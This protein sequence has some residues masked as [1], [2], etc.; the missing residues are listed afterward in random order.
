MAI[1]SYTTVKTLLGI[2]GTGEDA[3]LTLMAD[4][5]D[6]AIKNYVGYDIETAT[7]PDDGPTN[8]LGDTGY[9]SGHGTRLLLLRQRPVWN[10]SN[11]AIYQDQTGY[12]GANSD[13]AFAS[14]TLLTKG[15]DYVVRWDSYDGSTKV[16][17]SGIVERLGGAWPALPVYQR[18]HLMLNQQ[19]HRGNIYVTYKAGYSTVP[20]DITM[21]AG[22]WVSHVRRTMPQGGNIQSEG[23]GA[24]H[25][26][27][28]PLMGGMPDEVKVLLSKYRNRLL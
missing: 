2:S 24:Y 9:Y 6:R 26:A 10:D 4:Y 20:T 16:S 25:Y 13:G 8:G 12:F 17:R 22:F 1:I 19:E 7:Y 23:V 28:Q 3:K 14:A 27:M 5:V 21:A 18:G 15:T 11:L